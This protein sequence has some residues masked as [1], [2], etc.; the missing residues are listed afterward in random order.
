MKGFADNGVEGFLDCELDGGK[1]HH[2]A[3]ES[4]DPFQGVDDVVE[5][6]RGAGD[7]FAV[8]FEDGLGPHRKDR[9]AD[10]VKRTTGEYLL[11][12]ELYY[13]GGEGFELL[14]DEGHC[15]TFW[16]SL[17]NLFVVEAVIHSGMLF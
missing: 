2:E 9:V 15:A 10:A 17:P 16:T 1:G 8:E 11:Q 13:F 12:D 3:D 7:R 5:Q 14:V 6:Q 4:L